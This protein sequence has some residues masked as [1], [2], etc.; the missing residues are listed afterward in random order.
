MGKRV[1]SMTKGALALV[2]GMMCASTFAGGM[3]KEGATAGEGKMMDQT[4]K[5]ME[6]ERS[7]MMKSGSEMK[8]MEGDMKAMEAE[9]PKDMQHDMKKKEG[10]EMKE[11][12]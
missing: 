2:V 8:S 4:T 9:M 6:M 12:M 5:T 10:M 1:S 3:M 11:G 7:D